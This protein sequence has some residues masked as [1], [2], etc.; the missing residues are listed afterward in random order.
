[1]SQGMTKE[2]MGGA[3]SVRPRTFLES[4]VID[5]IKKQ[6]GTCTNKR[7]TSEK[8]KVVFKCRNGHFV[9]RDVRGIR[10]RGANCREC[11]ME[12]RLRVIADLA[13]SKGGRCLTRKLSRLSDKV[14]LQCA[15]G[16]EW[17]VDCGAAAKG[18]WCGVCGVSGWRIGL[19]DAKELAEKRGGKCL[20]K[21]CEG[22]ESTLKWQCA[23][24]HTWTAR[25]HGLLYQ[26]SW[27]P[28]CAVE[29]TKITLKDAQALAKK[30]GA[31]CMSK[32]C[33]GSRD[34]LSWRC[35]KGHRWKEA[36]FLA[37]RQNVFC[38]VC[39][40]E[41]A[42]E[43]LTA[44]LKNAW[45]ATNVKRRIQIAHEYARA[46]DGVC[47]SQ[48]Y[49]RRTPRFQWACKNGHEWEG[50]FAEVV[51][52]RSWCKQC[53]EGGDGVGV[54]ERRGLDEA[55]SIAAQRKGKCLSSEYKTQN[56]KLEWQCEKRH[57]W[58]ANLKNVKHRKSWCPVCSKVRGSLTE[59]QRIAE[60]HGG[61]LLSTKYTNVLERYKWRCSSGHVFRKTKSSAKKTF[62]R[63]CN[64]QTKIQKRM[65]L[66]R[67]RLGLKA[68]VR[69]GGGEEKELK[70]RAKGRRFLWACKNG[71]RFEEELPIVEKSGC[72]RCD[73]NELR[74]AELR[75]IADGCGGRLISDKYRGCNHEYD[76]E[77]EM[78]HTFQKTRTDAER[79]FCR[80]CT[81]EKR[82]WALSKD[83]LERVIGMANHFGF[84]VAQLD[85]W[86]ES[87]SFILECPNGHQVARRNAMSYRWKGHCPECERESKKSVRTK[88]REERAAR[89]ERLKQDIGM[90]TIENRKKY[91]SDDE[92]ALVL[93]ISKKTLQNRISMGL[94][95]P[96]YI[97]V[98]GSRRR[99]LTKD[100]EAWILS[101]RSTDGLSTE[102]AM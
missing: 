57:T 82:K 13:A 3:D 50:G 29:K 32:K 65:K 100:V 35:S 67:E 18:S 66:V 39:R 75:R 58:F 46:E 96:P 26:K 54:W 98:P 91:L 81:V 68:V 25:L 60:R 6:G 30:H 31:K 38:S 86:P 20:S 71:H 72:R 41:Q 80:R 97:A 5:L 17:D 2:S 43:I 7:I 8:S 63:E 55:N 78:G 92:T 49:S 42:G 74:L 99:W 59:L 84:S 11:R 34:N 73:Q 79:Q 21:S 102:V 64:S 12:E 40:K 48:A 36:Y 83:R 28:V 47:D 90:T 51:S 95:V 70:L 77:C 14:R 24:G 62:C 15:E 52:K 9:T 76:W 10:E 94:P 69:I 1:M 88:E 89:R 22:T 87:G 101:A 37:A 61:E 53:S 19:K 45:T 4:Q 23:E 27:C 56:E 93:G 33:D 16:H 85:S 44:A